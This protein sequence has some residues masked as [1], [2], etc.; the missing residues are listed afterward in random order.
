MAYSF[1]LRL[2]PWKKGAVP[3]DGFSPPVALGV[4]FL[5][6]VFLSLAAAIGPEPTRFDT[7]VAD[8]L[9]RDADS[10]ALSTAFWQD[11]TVLGSA[12][13]VTLVVVMVL[14]YLVLARHHRTALVVGACVLLAAT[15]SYVLKGVFE[16]PRPG[17]LQTLIALDTY[18]FPSGHSVIAATVYPVLAALV[19]RV[20]KGHRLKAYVLGSGVFLMVLTGVSRIHLGVHHAT[21]VLAGWAVGLAWALFAWSLLPRLQESGLVEAAPVAEEVD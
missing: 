20:V 17:A 18:S 11:V 7:L 2:N 4:V 3:R 12:S 15:S 6:M 10:S 21:D 5:A 13:L 1:L 16:R 9:T 8:L 19:A 14:G